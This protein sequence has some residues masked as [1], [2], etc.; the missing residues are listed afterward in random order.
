MIQVDPQVTSINLSSSESI[1]V[2]NGS[3]VNDSDGT[4]QATLLFPQGVQANM[5]LPDGTTQPLVAMHVRATEYTIGESGPEAMPAELPPNSGYTYAVEFSVD[6]APGASE[7]RFSQPLPFYLE[8]FLN[9]SIGTI[10]PLGSYN[11]SIGQWISSDSGRVIRVLNITG[12][13]A[14]LD[15]DGSNQTANASQ[16]AALN[17]TDAE[18]QQLATLYEPN[19]SLWRMPTPH[20]TEPWDANQG[21]RCED[22]DCEFPKQS[23]PNNPQMD[24]PNVKCGSIIGCQTQSLGEVVNITGTPFSLNYQSDR[25]PGRKAG[26]DIQLSGINVP[27][28]LI[29][30]VLEVSVAGRRF[31]QYFPPA[32]NQKTTFVW[33]ARMLIIVPYMGYSLLL[34]E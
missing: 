24:D 13:L 15:V 12:G 19:Q 17:I 26:L 28:K 16:L 20:F 1:Q 3:I 21:T 18:R 32:P 4:R 27:P 23:S 29:G 25:V 2:A 14:E 9:F 22:N 34:C 6:E 5:T 7:I 8:N 33:M 11:R 30:I 31:M 10:V